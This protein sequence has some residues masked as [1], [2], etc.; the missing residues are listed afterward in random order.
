M[1]L[2]RIENNL[3]PEIPRALSAIGA[4]F[5]KLSFREIVSNFGPEKFRKIIKAI[6]KQ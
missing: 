2:E 1:K 5:E 4:P 3:S 6:D